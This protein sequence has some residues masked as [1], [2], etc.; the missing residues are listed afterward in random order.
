MSFYQL[1]KERFAPDLGKYPDYAPQFRMV[2]RARR[3]DNT[4]ALAMRIADPLWML[5]RQWQFGEFKGEDNGSP[6]NVNIHYRKT[7]VQQYSADGINKKN[8]DNFPPEAIVEATTVPVLDLKSKVR[9]GQQYERFIKQ[10]TSAQTTDLIKKLR[11]RFPLTHEL[12]EEYELTKE[13][14][15]DQ[16]SERFFKLMRGKVIDGRLLL[17]HLQEV[18]YAY[19]LAGKSTEYAS[20][21]TATQQFKIWWTN[22]WVQPTTEQ[23]FWQQQHL[24][25]QFKLHD[26]KVE[27]NAP[28][29]QS[30]HLDWYSFDNAKVEGIEH[31]QPS[32]LKDQLPVNVSFPGMPDK[33]LFSFED[34][35]IDLSQMDVQAADLLKLLLLDFSLVS[36]GDWYTIP[37]PLALGELCWVEKIDVTDIFGVTTTIENDWVKGA[38]LSSNALQV[39]DAFK[40]RDNLPTEYVAK[41]HFLFVA[42]TT[43]F[44]QESAPQE[45]LLLLRDEYANMVWAVEKRL[46][47]AMGN[48]MDGFDLHLELYGQFQAVDPPPADNDVEAEQ[49]PAYQ[50]T[51]TVPTNWIP[52]LPE[53]EAGQQRNIHLRR[54]Y[55]VRKSV[56]QQGEPTDLKPLSRLAATDLTNIREEAIPR[57]GVRVQLTRQRV[58][59]TDGKTY[60]WQGR[61]VLTGRGEGNSGLKFDYLEK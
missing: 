39:W 40:I 51:S 55:M 16:S 46:P 29:Y 13:S 12:W 25:H 45:E 4:D 48:P 34:G 61:K 47:N 32:I 3:T 11:I 30:G 2:G 28:D 54:A 42:P 1:L 6:I 41:Q 26:E 33:R 36:G 5:G 56:N 44:K 22:F 18:D 52:Y 24:A 35:K 59:W 31:L 8:I 21:E 50:L 58:R 10:H 23:Q 43:T 19:P 9:I 27:L 7:K 15:M 20:L 49:L 38:V 53:H 14:R 37:L 60:L 17:Q 57:A